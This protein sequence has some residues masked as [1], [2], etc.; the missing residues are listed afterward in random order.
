MSRL[1][2]FYRGTATDSA[3]RSLADIWAYPDARMESVHDFIQ[4]LFPLTEPSRF[5]PYA[6]LLTDGEIAEFRSDPELQTNLKRSLD[7]FLAFLGLRYQDGEVIPAPDFAAKS[8]IWLSR[9]HNWMR[10]TRVLASTRLLGLEDRSRAFCEFLKSLKDGGR[11]AIQ[12]DT[13]EYWKQ[14]AFGHCE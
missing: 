4:W 10:I 13:F 2:D 14:A 11:S 6:P 5:N 12:D 8:E 7:V 1:I 9:N 3:G